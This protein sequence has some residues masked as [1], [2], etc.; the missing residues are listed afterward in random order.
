MAKKSNPVGRPPKPAGTKYETP[1][2]NLRLSDDD[3]ERQQ[4]AAAKLGKSWSEWARDVLNRLA[5][6]AKR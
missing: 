1:K 5:K 4:R 3:Y 2:R 6:G